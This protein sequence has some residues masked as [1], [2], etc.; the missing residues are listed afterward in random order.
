MWYACPGEVSPCRITRRATWRIAILVEVCF[1]DVIA[2]NLTLLVSCLYRHCRNFRA[3][4]FHFYRSWQFQRI[5]IIWSFRDRPPR[6]TLE[7]PYGIRIVSFC[8]RHPPDRLYCESALVRS[9]DPFGTVDLDA[10]EDPAVPPHLQL[11][12]RLVLVVDALTDRR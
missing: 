2:P 10:K 12:P 8:L 5:S 7:A 6:K 9:D 3:I 11:V 4:H 1:R